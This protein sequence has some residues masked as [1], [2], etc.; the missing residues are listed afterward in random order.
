M[1]QAHSGQRERAYKIEHH[2]EMP[3]ILLV[4]QGVNEESKNADHPVLEQPNPK[5]IGEVQP[6]F[7]VVIAM[8]ELH[9]DPGCHD[10]QHQNDLYQQ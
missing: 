9:D 1:L 4:H 10:H 5:Q 7:K 6:E 8:H 2:H 3:E